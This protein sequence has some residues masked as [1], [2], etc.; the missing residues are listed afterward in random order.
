[1]IQGSFLGDV[2]DGFWSEY[3]YEVDDVPVL[4]SNLYSCLCCRSQNFLSLSIKKFL[5]IL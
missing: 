1:M 3:F 2:L 5:I 4:E